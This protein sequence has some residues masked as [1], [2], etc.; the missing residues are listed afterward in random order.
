MCL[1]WINDLSE[2]GYLPVEL[3]TQLVSVKRR[4]DAAFHKHSNYFNGQGGHPC[5]DD[6]QLERI[7]TPTVKVT[8]I[9][10]NQMEPLGIV[11]PKPQG[12]QQVQILALSDPRGIGLQHLGHAN[13]TGGQVQFGIVFEQTKQ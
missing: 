5:I 4:R 6:P 10:S 2:G 7:G 3:G 8:Y 13:V 12:C 9:Q 1:A 11:E